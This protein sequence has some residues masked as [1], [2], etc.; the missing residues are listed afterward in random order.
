MRNKYLISFIALF[1]FAFIFGI[2]YSAWVS[3]DTVASSNT[4]NTQVTDWIFEDCGFAKFENVSNCNF[5]TATKEETIVNGSPEAI[6]L[7]NTAGTQNKAHTFN[8][9]FDRT[10]TVGEV[11]TFTIEF[12]YY[13]GQKREQTGKGFPKVQLLY[14]TSTVGGEQGGGETVNDKSPFVVTNIAEN[15][16]HLEYF[17]TSMCST[18]ADHQDTPI[19]PTKQINGIKIT[20]NYIYDFN[21]TTAFVVVDNM[22][23]D[24]KPTSRLGLF[25]RTTSFASGSF[26]W[27]KVAYSG[28]LHSC[29]ITTSDETI[30][31]W[32]TESTKSPF[33]IEGLSAGNVVVTA[34]LELGDEHVILSISNTIKVT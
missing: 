7:T 25:N 28:Q 15:W 27:F 21:S 6:R 5:L 20:D 13:Y 34:T 2:S 14:N 16:W 30:A 12:D 31:K 22:V 24:A 19:S 18:L 1:V 11:S 4:I 8:V 26:Y 32:D 33:Y 10:Y 9:A 29:V 17:V 23:F 3:L